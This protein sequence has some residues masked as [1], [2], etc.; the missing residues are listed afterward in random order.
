MQG[1]KY[2]KY[3]GKKTTEAPVPEGASEVHVL[4]W[5][6]PVPPHTDTE[7]T[8]LSNSSTAYSE[9]N[10]LGIGMRGI[11]SVISDDFFFFFSR[12]L[13]SYIMEQALRFT[14]HYNTGRNWKCEQRGKC[15]KQIPFEGY[16]LSICVSKKLHFK[17]SIQV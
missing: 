1:F 13:K 10:L 11:C 14:L 17:L 6:A 12:I 3:L 4:L 9:L 8:Q 5:G 2:R 16:I 7:Y 15:D